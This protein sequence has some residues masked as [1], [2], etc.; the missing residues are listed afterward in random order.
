MTKLVVEASP[1]IGREDRTDLSSQLLDVCTP[2][3]R[4]DVLVVLTHLRHGGFDLLPLRVAQVEV[5]QRA[6]V[7]AAVTEM[8]AL[9]RSACGPR[10]R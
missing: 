8:V 4:V 9:Y 10:R 2:R 3:L 6:H 5:T 7:L 1:L